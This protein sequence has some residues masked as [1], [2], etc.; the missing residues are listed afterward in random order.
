MYKLNNFEKI[1]VSLSLL[2]IVVLTTNIYYENKNK[3]TFIKTVNEN[4][5]LEE[6]IKKA[7][8][9]ALF[10]SNLNENRTAYKE[11][12]TALEDEKQTIYL[13]VEMVE[14]QIRCQRAFVL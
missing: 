3:E 5:Q 9:P 4:L 1:L 2:L 12:L 8:E 14:A 13:E 6:A 10:L 11:R 7:K